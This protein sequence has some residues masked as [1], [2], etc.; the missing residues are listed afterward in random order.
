VRALIHDHE[1][2]ARQY[3]VALAPEESGRVSLRTLLDAQADR[4]FTGKPATEP[5]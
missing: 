3:P 2:R 4:G 1:P 5:L